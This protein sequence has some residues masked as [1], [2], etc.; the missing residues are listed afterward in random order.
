MFIKLGS[1]GGIDDFHLNFLRGAAPRSIW[2]RD[3]ERTDMPLRVVV[4]GLFGDEGKGKIVAY[5]A[6]RDGVKIAA[7]G[8]VGPNAG[9]TVVIDGVRHRLR[10]IPSGFAY[11]EARLLIGP[12]VLVDPN[13][14][15]D[16]LE[17]TGTRNRIGV[18]YQAGIIEDKHID[19]DKGST[20]LR[21]KIGSTGSGCGPAQMERSG[22]TLKV[23]RE[24]DELKDI[25]TDVP[26]EMNEALN[27]GQNVL[28]EGTQ[29]TFLS[30]YYGTYPYVTSKDVTASSIC[31][32]VGIGPTRVDD[33]MVVL[34]SYVTRVGGGP[35]EGE[36]SLEEARRRDWLEV[37]TVTGRT[38][39]AAPF[40]FQLA[41]RSIMLNGATELALTK[42]D[43]VF[44]GDKRKRC[45][46]ELSDDAKAFVERIEDETNV[47]VSLIGTGENIS[48]VV[49]RA[50]S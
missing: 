16:E 37:A 48:D 4:G 29:G 8:G 40:N 6:Q 38:R 24:V 28:L 14:L 35:L 9:H 3:E 49:E 31:S 41:K 2:F 11:P 44:P 45:W 30:L 21:E 22:R 1:L 23:A 50:Q 27:L 34:K 19:E 25:L 13:V 5:L 33:V 18:D 39:R 12:G 7:R 46:E 32:D 43:I 36:I 17:I 26:L 20:R 15:L 42:V 47:P 10:Q